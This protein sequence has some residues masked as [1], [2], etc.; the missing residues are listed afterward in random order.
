M[1][2]DLS[3]FKREIAFLNAE[4]AD[5]IA[6][7]HKGSYSD[8]HPGLGKMINCPLCGHRRREVPEIPC[9]NSMFFV[10]AD[11]GAVRRQFMKKILHK[12]HSN[13]LRHQIHDMA[14]AMT[15]QKYENEKDTEQSAANAEKFRITTQLML[16]GLEGF[17]D[18]KTL[19]PLHGAPNLAERV[20]KNIRKHKANKKRKMQKESRRINRVA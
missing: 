12:R 11:E 2:I 3:D 14:L 9:C 17:H 4:L 19:I 10:V 1:N 15:G 6:R 20:I 18:P 13:K 16:E 8:R 5:G 7:L